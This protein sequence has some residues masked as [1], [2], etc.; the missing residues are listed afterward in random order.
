MLRQI[1]A[2][3]K[4]RREHRLKMRILKYVSRLNGGYSGTYVLNAKELVDHF[5]QYLTSTPEMQQGQKI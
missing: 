1:A 3:L 5:Y 4:M 2:Y